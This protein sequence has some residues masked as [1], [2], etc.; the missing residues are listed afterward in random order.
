MSI[1]AEA[2]LLQESGKPLE[3]KTL[4]LADPSAT[5]VVVEVEA[6]GLCHTDL[7]F[8]EGSVAPRMALPIVLGHE[9]VG[10]VRAAGERYT[11]LVGKKVLVPAVMPCG[12]C[13]FCRAGR[14]NACQKQ[15]MPGNDINGGFATHIVAPGASMVSLADAPAS[16]KT[17]SLSVVAD[18]VSTA[19]QA[20]VRSGLRAGDVAFVIGGGGV[21][22]FT[23][24]IAKALGAKTVVCDV[25]DARLEGLAPLGFDHVVNVKGRDVKDVRKELHGKAKEWGIPSL[26]FKVFECSGTAPGQTLAYTLLSNGATLLVVGFTRDTVTLRLSNLMAF[27]A[28]VHGSWGCPVEA[29]PAVLSLIYQ[30]KVVLEP[31]ISRAPM[32]KINEHLKALSEH[33]LEKR[34]VMDPRA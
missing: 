22:G 19:Y 21:G 28:T 27:D 15:K 1:R 25:Q 4:E 9:V 12:D 34:L 13:A 5:E 33:K 11:A 8:A 20:V 32:S 17:D 2:W 31:F 7:G 26:N 23:A 30:G 6:C 10:T 24:Q 18:A 16:V 3:K 14:G 29:Y